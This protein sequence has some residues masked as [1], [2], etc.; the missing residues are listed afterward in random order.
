MRSENWP[1][2]VFSTTLAVLRPTRG[3]A[4]KAFG[5]LAPVF[6]HQNFAGFN[7]VF[8]LG[9]KQ[10]NGLDVSLESIDAQI[11]KGLCAV[12]GSEQRPGGFIN[13]KVCGLGG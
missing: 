9:V 13:A 10:T 6:V 4:R 2:A 11:L 5:Y 3:S 8:S 7:G 1:K 12:G